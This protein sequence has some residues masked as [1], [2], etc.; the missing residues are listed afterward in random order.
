LEVVDAPHVFQGWEH[1]CG[2]ASIPVSERAWDDG[3]PAYFD[4]SRPVFGRFSWSITTADDK[5]T[6]EAKM[7]QRE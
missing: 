2:P 4:V 5:A 6:R 7:I 1:T 3:D